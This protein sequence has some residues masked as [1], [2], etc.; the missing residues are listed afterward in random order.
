MANT[1]SRSGRSRSTR[2]D[3]R[4]AVTSALDRVAAQPTNVSQ[5]TTTATPP[6]AAKV[7][8]TARPRSAAKVYN[9]AQ[10]RGAA[11]VYN[12]ASVASTAS[13]SARPAAQPRSAA[14]RQAAQP[15]SVAK[16]YTTTSAT[17][18]RR[19][20]I[21]EPAPVD[22]SGEYRAIRHDLKRV[23][24]WASVLIITMIALAFLVPNL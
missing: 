14:K 15:R 3:R 12:A 21:G 11:K 22:H 2:R 9:T 17:A 13:T 10:P 6:S 19:S 7:Y 16:V 4:A 8:T 23:L 5:A 18:P 20:Y 1:K 24:L